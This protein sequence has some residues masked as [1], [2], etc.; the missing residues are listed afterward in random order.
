MENVEWVPPLS[1]ETCWEKKN[2]KQTRV[3]SVLSLWVCLHLTVKA[4]EGSE[5]TWQFL[6]EN[7]WKRNEINQ[8]LNLNYQQKGR[9]I[10]RRW[11]LIA[12]LSPPIRTMVWKR[13]LL[14]V[15]FYIFFCNEKVYQVTTSNSLEN[16]RL[17]KLFFLELNTSKLKMKDVSKA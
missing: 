17:F 14:K 2:P 7:Q 12:N 8:L 3:R 11:F 9:L 6:G 16:Q 4:R 5:E 1:T 10:W 13:L 15:S